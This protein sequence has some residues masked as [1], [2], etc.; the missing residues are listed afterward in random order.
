MSLRK[1]HDFV[2]VGSVGSARV[3]HEEVSDHA[4]MMAALRGN[5]LS[6]GVVTC[7]YVGGRL[8]MSD[9]DNEHRTNIGFSV[10]ANGDVLIA[11]LGIGYILRAIVDEKDSVNEVAWDR[12]LR[13]KRPKVRSI[14]VV[15]RSQDVIDLIAPLFPT[16]NVICADIFEWR[17]E[18]G[19]KYDTIY[20]DIWPDMCVD[21]LK[22]MATLHRRFGGSLN[23]ANSYAWMESWGRDVLRV[24]KRK[25]AR[26]GY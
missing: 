26:R 20:F 16:V 24:Q 8:W 1:M 19:V 2:P 3:T 7:L 12:M 18:K 21:N 9:G 6:P 13:G 15:E 17:P 25:E 23:R 5:L 22:G 4:A 11:G 14:T 10:S